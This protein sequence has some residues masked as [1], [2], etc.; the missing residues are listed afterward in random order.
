MSLNIDRSSSSN[1]ENGAEES[2][3]GSQIG[4]PSKERSTSNNE[5][6]DAVIREP[7]LVCKDINVTHEKPIEKERRNDWQGAM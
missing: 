4:P 7:A 3:G 1:M 5:E 6:Q 2:G